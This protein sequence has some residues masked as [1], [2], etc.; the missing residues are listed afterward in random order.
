MFEI[1][2]VVVQRLIRGKFGGFGRDVGRLVREIGGVGVGGGNLVV[3]VDT[4]V[5]IMNAYGR[6]KLESGIV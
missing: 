2:C 3:M 6:Q 1:V 4:V 5:E